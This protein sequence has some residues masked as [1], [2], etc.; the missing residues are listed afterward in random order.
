MGIE[1]PVSRIRTRVRECARER[2]EQRLEEIR[3]A[4]KHHLVGTVARLILR[5]QDDPTAIQILLVWRQ[6]VMP[7]E[8]ER[9]AAIATLCDDL[10]DLL[11]WEHAIWSEGQVLLYAG[12]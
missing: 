1:S 9:Q 2:L 3:A 7:S 10:A 6:L 5:S 11:D 12:G 4:K 8:E